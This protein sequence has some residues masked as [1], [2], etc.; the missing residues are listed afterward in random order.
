[1]TNFASN[2]ASDSTT[3]SPES[4]LS[5]SDLPGPALIRQAEEITAEW[6]TTVL[7]A[8]GT[9]SGTQS[10][11]TVEAVTFGAD[12]GLMGSLYRTSLTY[13]SDAEGP[14]SVVVKMPMDDPAQRGVA[15]M[16]NFFGRE[17]TFYAERAQSTPYATAE[18]FA[19]IS[20]LGETTDFVIVMEDLGHLTQIDQ[21]AGAT[22]NEIDAAVTAI[23]KQHA[24]YWERD[25]LEALSDPFM[26]IDGPLYLAA[27]PSVFA[28]GWVNTKIYGA[29]ELTPEVIE[30]GDNYGDH[31]PHLLDQL[32]SPPTLVHGDFR[33]DNL[34]LDDANELTV[35][36]FQISGVGCGIYDIGYFMAQSVKPDLRKEN[37][38]RVVRLYCD[39]LLNEGITVDYDE[40]L[41]KYRMGFAFFLIYAATSFQSWEA[42]DGRQHELMLAML[43]R[44]TA[45]IVDNGS[46]DLLPPLG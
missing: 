28:G 9:L 15:D 5:G 1:M 4:E 39:T 36:D 46:L 12:A 38:E 19:N 24:Q 35:I 10:V 17:T 32:A 6:M 23:A 34:M 7:H 22:V 13:T 18:I 37:D 25:D 29:E 45:A 41:S 44:S 33:G 27:L 42:F 3:S 31:I 20:D 21:V 30:F 26:R 43:R 16:L 2:A 14:A 8:H 40:T 11:R